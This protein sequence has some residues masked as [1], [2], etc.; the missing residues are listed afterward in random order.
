MNVLL[1]TPEGFLGWCT[2]IAA[3]MIFLALV[4]AVVRLIRGPGLPDRAVALDLISMLL[5]AFLV[6]FAFATDM[7]AYLDASLALALVGFLGTVA[8][9]RL[10]DHEADEDH[11]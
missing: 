2:N 10:I 1:V 3:F 5:V 4:L 6:L 8:F 9:A 7:H 11:S